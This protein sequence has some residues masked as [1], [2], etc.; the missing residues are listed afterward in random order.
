MATQSERRVLI[1][2]DDR[3]F[4]ASLGELFASWGFEY[5]AAFCTES[6]LKKFKEFNVQVALVD[7]RLGTQNGLDLLSQLKEFNPN[8]I[9]IMMTAYSDIDTLTST[10]KQGA[11]DYL[12]K[13]F[14]PCDLLK[15]LDRCFEKIRLEDEK[16]ALQQQLHQVQKLESLGIMA[17]G[18]AHDFNNILAI[19]FGNTNLALEKMKGIPFQ[20]CP[21][22]NR[23]S[24]EGN[25][26]QILQ[27]S[28]RATELVNQILVFSRQE[29]Q[30]YETIDPVKAL[31]ES[32]NLLRSIIPTTVNI[33][34]ELDEPCGLIN[35]DP[36]QIHQILMNLCGNSVHAMNDTGELL[37]K[38]ESV[39]LLAA[40]FGSHSDQPPGTYARLTIADS[41]S[42]IPTEIMGRIFDPFFTTKAVGE[43]TGIGLAAVHSIVKN[44]RG[45]I[46]VDSSMGKGTI[47]HIDFPQVK[48][49]LSHKE[50]IP[51]PRNLGMQQR[52]LFIDDEIAIVKIANEI[53][54]QL[55]YRVVAKTDSTDAFEL[56]KS[57]PEEFDLVITDLNMPHISGLDMAEEMLKIRPNLPVILC[58]GYFPQRIDQR[59]KDI[60]IS[61]CC[62][63]P[64]SIEDLSRVVFASLG[65][66]SDMAS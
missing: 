26:N 35:A 64:L 44:H 60:G 12:N 21:A 23:S 55:G 11:Y 56:F 5:E 53:L 17:G 52:I 15:S 63:K 54:Q 4:V 50:E 8:L 57:R 62:I 29:Q 24:L 30:S 34:Q 27:A 47:F 13:P 31:T 32:L 38:L 43:G 14:A 49:T 36:T 61:E 16:A 65:Q 18:I 42:G 46:E 19:I 33:S 41:G 7:I 59:I 9:C 66:C 3:D 20:K 58:S 37:V 40:D 28:S 6:A 1:V 10:L 48:G 39:D 2:D 51:A 45:Y 22:E 25:L